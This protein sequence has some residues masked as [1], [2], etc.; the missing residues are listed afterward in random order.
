MKQ[1]VTSLIESGKVMDENLNDSDITEKVR[2]VSQ[3]VDTH[4]RSSCHFAIGLAGLG[5]IEFRTAQYYLRKDG[6]KGGYLL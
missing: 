2:E 1:N 3:L 6:W 5:N 4:V